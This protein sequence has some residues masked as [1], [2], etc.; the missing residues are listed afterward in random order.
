[1]ESLM[2]NLFALLLLL[3]I[4]SQIWQVI[5]LLGQL[6]SSWQSSKIWLLTLLITVIS[7]ALLHLNSF[8]NFA[9][10][11]P[12]FYDGVKLQNG[13]GGLGIFCNLAIISLGV[14]KELSLK[15]IKTL[16]R[17]PLIGLLVG[18]ILQTHQLLAVFLLVEMA[19][20]VMLF[21]K[22][23]DYHL[24]FRTNI[25][26]MFA[27]IIL[28]SIWVMAPEKKWLLMVPFCVYYYYRLVLLR[29]IVMGQWIKSK[30]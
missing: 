19:I 25:K 11:H 18:L 12:G 3:L 22:R 14:I 7:I 21:K 15:K 6:N 24:Y 10:I 28:F 1:M 26:S 29:T 9:I 17:L 16:W 8:L 23:N 2:H 13:L 20:W 5:K 27:L 4:L 30:K